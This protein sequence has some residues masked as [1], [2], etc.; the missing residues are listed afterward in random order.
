MNSQY[1]RYLP[2]KQK[3]ENKEHLPYVSIVPEMFGVINNVKLKKKNE[4][5]L[6]IRV[7][8]HDI[9]LLDAIAK[10]DGIS[11]SALIN[12][13]LYNYFL[14]ELKEIKDMDACALLAQTVDDQVNYDVLNMPWTYDAFN[15]CFKGIL[16]NIMTYNSFDQQQYE[17]D[18]YSSEIYLGLIKK[19]KALKND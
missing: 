6:N 2:T 5:K 9:Y 13:I 14:G 17:E 11:R 1:I 7:K 16:R 12:K 10:H 3:I 18:V 19:L 4:R 8:Q 15:G